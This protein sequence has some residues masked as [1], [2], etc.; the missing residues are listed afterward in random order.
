MACFESKQWSTTS[1]LLLETIKPPRTTKNPNKSR[2]NIKK[3]HHQRSHQKPWGFPFK[4]RQKPNPSTL[5]PFNDSPGSFRRAGSLTAQEKTK[6]SPSRSRVARLFR[7]GSIIF[8]GV[9]WDVNDYDM[10]FQDFR[11]SIMVC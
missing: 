2:K 9:L 10:G 11:G 5:Q 6:S 8:Y 3:K 7:H 1:S 4:T